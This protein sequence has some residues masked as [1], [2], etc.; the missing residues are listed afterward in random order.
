M[1]AVAKKGGLELF[2]V[3][4]CGPFGL[5]ADTVIVKSA[6]LF[7]ECGDVAAQRRNFIT[8]SEIIESTASGDGENQNGKGD[9]S[10]CGGADF[11]VSSTVAAHGEV[12]VCG[13][14]ES[15]EG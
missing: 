15:E 1:E 2:R 10:V 9:D 7:F 13:G 5:C 3:G 14:K 4:A 12:L 6:R 8:E 11:R